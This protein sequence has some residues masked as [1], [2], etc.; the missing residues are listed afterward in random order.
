MEG[1][2]SSKVSIVVRIHLGPPN[3]IKMNIQE[4]IKNAH[5][6][7]YDGIAPEGFVLIPEE[8]VNE[9]KDFDK[10]KEFISDEKWLEKRSKEILNSIFSQE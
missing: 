8:V 4:K 1:H 2:D 3:K 6:H 9:L 7:K 5:Y 10:W